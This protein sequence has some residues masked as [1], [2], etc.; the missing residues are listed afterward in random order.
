MNQLTV[1]KLKEIL[2]EMKD[3]D[4][5][6]LGD[7]EE[8]NGLHSAYFCQKM[9]GNEISSITYGTIRKGGVLIS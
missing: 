9:S 7:D 3:T 2:S 6:Y 1:K 4:V 8:L 5:I